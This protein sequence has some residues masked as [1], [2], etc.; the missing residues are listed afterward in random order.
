MVNDMKPTC[1]LNTNTDEQNTPSGFHPT[2]KN[3][4]VRMKLELRNIE[5]GYGKRTVLS[6]INLEVNTGEIVC[7]IGPNGVGKTTLFKAILGLKKPTNGSIFLNGIDV[8]RW[9][10]KEFARC[11]AY[12]PQAH[13]TPFPFSVLD[14]VLFGRTAHLG[15]FDSP[16]RK[17]RVI[18]DEC[19]DIL[20]ISHLRNQPFTQLSGGERQ[21]V[22]IARALAQQ[23][24]FL[25]LDE[26]TSNLDFGN[27]VK[28][29]NHINELK[30]KS[31]GIFMAT[32]SPDHAFM[33]ASKVVI[34]HNGGLMRFGDPETIITEES[35]K[36]VYGVDVLVINSPG[37]HE[38]KRKVCVPMI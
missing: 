15:S 32:H 28:V 25:V 30:N 12:V 27:Q 19:L 22:I 17:D 20:N 26:P 24:Q 21:M 5:L 35:L 8:S 34:V 29:L 36:K 3:N 11:I 2:L 23:P 4:F 10:H 18:A 9:N 37:K 13:N 6:D 33:C 7:L 16:G 14:V 31:L 1:F 38:T